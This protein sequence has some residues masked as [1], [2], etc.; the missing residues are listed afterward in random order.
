MAK[1]VEGIYGRTAVPPENLI[2]LA[3]APVAGFSKTRLCP[4]CSPAQAALL[5][6]S[7]LIDTL[8]AVLRTPCDRRVL[9][10]DQGSSP[11]DAPSSRWWRRGFDV[12]AQG[13]GGLGERLAQ[14]FADVGGPSF[15]VAMDTPQVTPR[16]LRAGLDLLRSHDATLGLAEDGGYWGIGLAVPR[17]DVFDGVPMSDASTGSAQLDRLLALGLS[18][19]ELPVIRDVDTFADAVTV[20]GLAP[21]GRFAAAV[22]RV[23]PGWGVTPG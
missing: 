2:V 3:K 14:A 8:D 21:N 5:A 9:V 17:R 18:I 7:A 10:F 19:A 22:R 16:L 4:P 6:E 11:D 12:I 20:A 1:I 15:L 23:T 13:A